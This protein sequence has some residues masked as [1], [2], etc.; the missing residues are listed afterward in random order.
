M[1]GLG[2]SMVNSSFSGGLP[3]IS[4]LGTHTINLYDAAAADSGT[5]APAASSESFGDIRL[6]AG[7]AYYTGSPSDYTATSL[8]VRNNTTNP[9]G[10]FTELLSGD[11]QLDSEVNLANANA[12]FI[13]FDNDSPM[14]DIDLGSSSG[15]AQAH[16]GS[17]NNSFTFNLTFKN[18]YYDG[19]RTVSATLLLTDSDAP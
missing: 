9:G 13:F 5:G 18:A 16:N 15:S 4:E 1:L 12:I 3:P 7:S 2:S 14:D 19:T 8:S 10:V 11:L 17:G 6:A